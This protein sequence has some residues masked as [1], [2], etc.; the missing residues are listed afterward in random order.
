LVR[1]TLLIGKQQFRERNGG[2]RRQL[3]C[4]NWRWHPVCVRGSA[5]SDRES[6]QGGQDRALRF[7][8]VEYSGLKASAKVRRYHQPDATRRTLSLSLARPVVVRPDD[9]KFGPESLTVGL[10][11]VAREPSRACAGA[12][13]ISPLPPNLLP[14]AR[15]PFITADRDELRA[16]PG[17]GPIL[18][19]RR[20]RDAR[21]WQ[22]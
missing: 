10:P 9:R 5:E 19:I 18:P 2:S 3:K 22:D 8:K 13:G 20:A 11:L 7:G 12:D 17:S 16:A 1:K 14:R 6:G 4:E 21:G 15:Q